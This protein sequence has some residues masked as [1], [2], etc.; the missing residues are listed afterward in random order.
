MERFTARL[1]PRT[2][3]GPGTYGFLLGDAANAIHFW[4]GRPFRDA[5]FV[6]HEAAMS[7]LQYRHKSRAWNSMITTDEHGVTR[8]IKDK[9]QESL[10]E[11]LEQ[12]R[13]LDRDAD[14]EALMRQLRAIRDRLAPRVPGMP[15]DATLLK[16][17][18]TLHSQTL[19]TLVRSGAWD[20]RIVDGEEVDIDIFYPAERLDRPRSGEWFRA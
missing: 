18:D 5:D 3:T 1:Y 15:D 7:M 10:S 4:R 16:H 20:T 12:G 13:A 17:L 14:L 11:S 9:I 6:R 8:A 19:Y 2:S